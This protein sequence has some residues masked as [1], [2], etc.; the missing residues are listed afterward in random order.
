MAWLLASLFLFQGPGEA[1]NLVQAPPREVKRV[2]WDLFE[3]TEVWVLLLPGGP[4]GEPPPRVNLVFQAFFPGRAKRD[5][6]TGLP[7]WPKGE[8]QRLALRAQ[9][10]PL[11][12]TMTFP[13]DLSL[14]LVVDDETFDLGAACVPGAWPAPQCQLLFPG[15]ESAA[16]GVSVE[17]QPS[18]LQRLA[19]ARVVSGTALGFPIILSS[20]DLGAVSKF[21]E[22]VHLKMDPQKEDA[23]EQ[24]VGVVVALFVVAIAKMT[25][26]ASRR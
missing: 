9:L 22:A 5:P 2:Y 23:A 25:T 13:R 8:P 18:L 3:T 16:N 12:E 1:W 17:V 20:D 14:R 26:V 21:A 19:K 10:F 7:Q 4:K 6:N 24:A 15:P 11:T